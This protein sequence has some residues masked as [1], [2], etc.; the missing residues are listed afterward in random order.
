MS[1]SPPRPRRALSARGGRVTSD[2]DER[3]RRILAEALAVPDEADARELTHGFHSYPA[4]FHPLLCRRLLA[5]APPTVTVLD[6]FVGSGT[7]L[8]EACVRGARG[9]GVDA[10]PLAVALT[11]L[12]ATPWPPEKR[13]QLVERAQAASARSLERVKKRARTVTRGDEY[14]DPAKYQ[15]HVFRELVGLKE[16]IETEPDEWTRDA[17]RLVLSSLVVKVSKQRADTAPSTVER[18]IGKGLASRLLARKADELARAMAQ[19]AAAVPPSAPPPDVRLG[20]A[21]KLGHV[22]DGSVDIIITSPPY[23]GTYDYAEHHARRFGWL[24][25]DDKKLRLHEIGARRQQRA[26]DDDTLAEWQRD[27]DAFVREMARVLAKRGAAF[28]NIGDSTVGR[29]AVAGDRALRAAATRAGLA[30]IA[31]A[32]E[33][34]PNFYRRGARRNEHLIMLAR[35]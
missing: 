32:A 34:R 21:R 9:I 29:R 11:R 8:I 20:D 35:P 2:G 27:V 16:E 13:A 1:T 6:P 7:T 31:S 25:L 15:P 4:R 33:D 17:L 30:V 22:P 18:T 19:Y 12:K 24:G 10:N 23:V 14:D 26:T 5:E 28:V 3:W